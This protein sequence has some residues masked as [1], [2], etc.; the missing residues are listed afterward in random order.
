MAEVES[1]STATT[2][3][4]VAKLFDNIVGVYQP[5]SVLLQHVQACESKLKD[6][7]NV[8]GRFDRDPTSVESLDPVAKPDNVYL[9]IPINDLLQSSRKYVR[10]IWK[11][12]RDS[13]YHQIFAEN[14]L[15]A[16]LF[17]WRKSNHSIEPKIAV[18][19]A[20]ILD[21][22]SIVLLVMIPIHETGDVWIQ[23][24]P[25]NGGESVNIDWHPGSVILVPGTSD[26]RLRGK[27]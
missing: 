23:A 4:L 3:P 8:Q 27:G 2:V 9:V 7:E 22:S 15:L 20:G 6:D 17:D 13:Y 26:L 14:A 1:D 25:A 21:L 19:Q 18:M 12:F 11:E 10:P 16:P 24:R 5:T